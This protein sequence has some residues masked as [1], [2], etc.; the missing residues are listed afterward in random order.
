MYLHTLSHIYTEREKRDDY[1]HDIEHDV[2][3]SP[4]LVHY[5]IIFICHRHP[6]KAF[7]GN[8]NYCSI[9]QYQFKWNVLIL[10]KLY[11]HNNAI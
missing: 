6:W 3:H 11:L 8:V 2:T 10:C 9:S 1:K 7:R 5:Y 4:I